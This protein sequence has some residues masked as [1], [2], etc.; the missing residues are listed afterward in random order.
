RGCPNRPPLYSGIMGLLH[1]LIDFN[2]LI[3]NYFCRS[4]GDYSNGAAWY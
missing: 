2:R 3:I 4:L 1:C